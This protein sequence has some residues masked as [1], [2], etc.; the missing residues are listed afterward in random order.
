M[1][2]SPDL[3]V[4]Q[5]A[6]T[7]RFRGLT[8]RDGMLLRG[9]AGWGEFAPFWDYDDLAA[10]AWWRSAREAADLGWPEPVRSSVEVNV[11]IP[12]VDAVTAARLV[13]ESG[14]CRT[15]KV[16]VAE[17]GQGLGAEVERLE[18]VRAALGPGGAIRI[19]ANGAWDV[20]TAIS[21]LPVLDRAAGGLEYVEQPC[22]SVEEL[23][24]VRRAASVRVAADESVR[25]AEDP[26]AVARAGAADILVL[27]VA[28]LGGVRACLELAERAGL[29]VVVS[30][31]LETSVGLAAGLALAAALPELPF[32]CGLATAQLLASDV[33]SAPLLPVDGRIAVRPVVVDEALLSRSAGDEELDRPLEA[34]GGGRAGGAA[35]SGAPSSPATLAARVLVSA[36]VDLGVR[37]VVLAP[38]SRSAPLAYAL[39]EAALA[40]DDPARD[41]QA[42]VVDL[43]VRVD[44]RE[45][46]FLALGLARAARLAGDARPV[47]VVTTSGSAVA[48][49]LPAVLEAHHSGLPLLLLTADRPHELR[50]T[51]ANQTTQQPGLLGPVRLAVDVPAPVGLPDEPRTL[52]NLASRAVAAALGTRTRQPGPV[53]LDLAYREPLVP[54]PEAWPAPSR[55]GITRV[56]AAAPSAAPELARGPRTLVVAGD[57][58]GPAAADLA[59]QGGWPLLAEPSSGSCHGPQRVG[60][61]RLVLGASALTARVERVVVLGRPTLSRPVQALLAAAPE[62]LVVAPDG[63]PWT[64]PARRVDRVL[65]AVPVVT[66]GPVD[67][68]GWARSW[69]AAGRTAA[70]AVGEVLAEASREAAAIGAVPGQVLAAALARATGPDDVLLVGA[71]NPVRDLD[72]VGGWPEPRVVVANRGLA[73][74]DGAVSTATGLALG[75][76]R[77]VRAYLGDLTALHGIAGLLVGPMERRPDLQLVVAHDGGGSIFATLEHGDERL[78]HL[79]ERVFATPHGADLASL[80]AGYGVAHRHAGPAELDAVLA[81]PVVG[82]SLVEVRVDRAGRRAVDERLAAA[83][84]DAL[85]AAGGAGEV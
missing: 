3:R 47:A 45:A 36:L 29:P 10:L 85:D 46:G 31:A 78:A 39:A 49:L 34:A 66:G 61:Y 73:G 77:P 72:L 54:G 41:P 21:R 80:C 71:S 8:A 62:V 30:S 63:L 67:D 20:G 43:H 1:G 79:V 28:P 35:M 17:A 27:K 37:E 32:A 5:V 53:H 9:E 12:A 69:L 64:D 82:T 23:A 52:R 48:H 81:E 68:G 2:S 16:K 51:G 74:I 15:A 55:E 56:D 11:T 13:R 44:E 59:E 22:A 83:V 18:A 7:Q 50:G 14:G 25:R 70:A 26:L 60:A 24:E 84:R 42:P 19:D 75:L 6:L 38:G 40:P 76:G 33:T 4:Y 65:A 57:G 58:A